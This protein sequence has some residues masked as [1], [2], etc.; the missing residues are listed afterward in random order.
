[1]TD[2]DISLSLCNNESVDD[3]SSI[4]QETDKHVDEAETVGAFE[5]A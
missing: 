4:R 5:C 1:V 2:L 3:I